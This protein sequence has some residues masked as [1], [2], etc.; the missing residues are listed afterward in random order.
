M[1]NIRFPFN[2]FPVIFFIDEQSFLRAKL[3]EHFECGR[4]YAVGIVFEN[5]LI[6]GLSSIQFGLYVCVVHTM[7]IIS[8]HLHIVFVGAGTIKNQKSKWW[9]FD[10]RFKQYHRNKIDFFFI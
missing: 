6:S 2:S 3:V 5:L 9:F 1:N 7:Q 10:A 8:I 4:S